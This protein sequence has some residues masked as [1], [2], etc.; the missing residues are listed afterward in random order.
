MT[1]SLTASRLT[2]EAHLDVIGHIDGIALTCDGEVISIFD[3]MWDA[4]LAL[5]NARLAAREANLMLGALISPAFTTNH[6]LEATAA[7]L[8]QRFQS[9]G[10]A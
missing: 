9:D 8:R 4:R 5:R 7:D 2:Q 10:E 1:L 6:A 3:S